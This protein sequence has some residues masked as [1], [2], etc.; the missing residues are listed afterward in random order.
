MIFYILIIIIYYKIVTSIHVGPCV[1]GMDTFDNDCV[2]G[3]LVRMTRDH[4]CFLR[5]QVA[6]KKPAIPYYVCAMTKSN[7]SPP[8]LKMV[9]TFRH[10]LTSIYP[11]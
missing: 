8:K 2:F 1:L 4:A 7:V 11:E 10:F 6:T 5:N 9:S 3:N